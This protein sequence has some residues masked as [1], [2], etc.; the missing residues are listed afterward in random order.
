LVGQ[1]V[2]IVKYKRIDLTVP[3][4]QRKGSALG[5]QT[6]ASG[7]DL[8]EDRPKTAKPSADIWVATSNHFG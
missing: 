1:Q 5:I 8:H 6:V 7:E 2:N 3:S 4:L